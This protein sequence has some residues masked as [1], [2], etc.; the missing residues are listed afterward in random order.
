MF[1]VGDRVVYPMYGA[2]IIEAIEEQE[3]LG[4]RE[5]YY[6][7]HL[8]FGDLRMLIPVDRAEESR[9]RDVIEPEEVQRVLTIL[10]GERSK[11]ISNW[12]VRFR[13]NMNKLK[14]GDPYKVA[15]VVR[16]L[17]ARER[18]QG[19]SSREQRCLEQARTILGS[20]LMLATG[21]SKEKIENLL[22]G[23]MQAG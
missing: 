11:P 2:G 12:N 22:D 10:E 15:E 3:V 13:T 17:S 5:L 21:Q 9:L 23:T 14:S 20:E 8:P 6:V 7:I 19:L 18:K 4:E 1:Q 16:D